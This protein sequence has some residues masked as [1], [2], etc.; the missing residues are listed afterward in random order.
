MLNR[1]VLKGKI[2]AQGLLKGKINAQVLLVGKMAKATVYHSGKEEYTDYEG[3]YEVT[4]K[5][6]EQS[7]PTKNKYMLD[8]VTVKSIP[9]FSVSNGTGGNTVYIGNEV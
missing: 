8:D 6:V 4:P 5:V 2:V 9:Y 1:G 3:D 7:L